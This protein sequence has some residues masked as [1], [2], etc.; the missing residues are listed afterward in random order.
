MATRRVFRLLFVLTRVCGALR[1]P[2]AL[3]ASQQL[4]AA[5]FARSRAPRLQFG[6]EPEP[7]DPADAVD[8]E[9][10]QQWDDSDGG[11]GQQRRGLGL[12]SGVDIGD[13]NCQRKP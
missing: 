7:V 3:L 2:P 5:D 12:V 1:V 9:L 10:P 4:P 8:A 6:D 11:R 13:G